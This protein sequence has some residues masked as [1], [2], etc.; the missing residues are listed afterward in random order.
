MTRWSD[1]D[2][3]TRNIILTFVVIVAIIIIVAWYGYFTGAWEQ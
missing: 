1:L 3:R 2:L